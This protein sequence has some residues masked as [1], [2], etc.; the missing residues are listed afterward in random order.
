M[1]VRFNGFEMDTDQCR[2]MRMGEQVRME[3]L[4]FDLLRVL[5]ENR[6]QLVPREEIA[7]AIWGQGVFIDSTNGINTAIR[8]VRTALDLPESNGDGDGRDRLIETV[9]KRGYRFNTPPSFEMVEETVA[10]PAALT[11]AGGERH[12]RSWAVGAVALAIIAAGAAVFWRTVQ[13]TVTLEPLAWRPITNSI[14][15]F[16][17]I[18]T[19]GR[20]VF[21]TDFTEQGCRPFAVSAEGGDARPL[22][23]P[24][25]NAWVLDASLDHHLLL[26]VREDCKS[27]VMAGALWE[28]DVNSGR[29]HRVD[30]APMQDAAYSADGRMLAVARGN[31]LW[32]ERRDGTEP[33]RLV[34][35]D[36]LIYFPKWSPDGKHIRYFSGS[37]SG[38]TLW[39]IDPESGEK[40]GI[41]DFDLDSMGGVWTSDSR[42]FLYVKRHE[43]LMEATSN[44]RPVFLRKRQ[45]TAGPVEYAAPTMAYG[46]NRLF[47][48][49]NQ[50]L[51][52]LMRY[53][54]TTHQTEPFLGGISA[55][56]LDFSRDGS[57]VAWV[58]YPERGLWVAKADGSNA[59]Q[60]LSPG[61][62]LTAGMPRFS[63]DG[64]TIAFTG[65]TQAAAPQR[66]G[67]HLYL[68]A[69]AG[70][71][72]VQLL[73]GSLAS[74]QVAPTW[75]S[76]GSRLLYRKDLPTPGETVL[77]NDALAILDL[78]TGVEAILPGSGHKFN[79]RWSPNGLQIVATPNDESELDVYT[80]A[81]G[82]WR[83]VS[84]Q[85][86]DFPSW[87]ADSRYIYF[88][89]RD[90]QET[91]LCRLQ[92]LSGETETLTS[93][94][95]VNRAIDDVWGQWAGVTPDGSP[96]FLAGAEVQ[97]LYSVDL[98]R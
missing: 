69:A 30:Q 12:W 96:I 86:A 25:A 38:G 42:Q 8:K 14:H 34:Q 70:G 40:K 78:R 22:S 74:N 17:R 28:L 61:S 51:G 56:M 1:I 67:M 3:K 16:Y 94:A 62:G 37:Q 10:G 87:S 32:T 46:A 18:A 55:E 79:Q 9:V 90:A 44:W 24:F 11:R 98:G 75:S 80:L 31:D 50:R 45:L 27:L 58:S 77:G 5:I 76:D 20:S 6:D 36:H 63:P 54:L 93:L 19:D 84:H 85:V 60:I 21:W 97:R 47:V 26:N 59:R 53:N 82:T 23:V 48:I 89:S 41:G 29:T 33:R 83:T 66:P 95:K 91:Y 72:P 57:H 49:G 92:V 4:P 65:E 52:A 64:S 13:S 43:L 7:A 88:V 68:I 2:L 73:A 71:K 15:S 39:E 81:D 35:S